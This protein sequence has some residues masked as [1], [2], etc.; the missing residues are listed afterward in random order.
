MGYTTYFSGSLEFNKPVTEQLR[1]YINRFSYTRRMPRNNEKIKEIYPNWKELCFFGELGNNGEYFAPM[2]IN[3]GQDRDDSIIDYNGYSC[4]VHPG[5]WCQW[6]INDNGELEWD[7][8]EKFYEYEEWLNYLI[9]HFFK[10]LGY[11]LNGDITWEGEDSDDFGTI[12]VIDNVVEMHYGTK[13]MSM[14][15]LKTDDL[16][17]ELENRGYK[18][19]TN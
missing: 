7:G 12:H 13:I 2:S 3:Y 9:I 6:I 10:P 5:L 11:V 19:S 14:S 15:E 16:I 1:D 4:S 8:G 18:V 17:E